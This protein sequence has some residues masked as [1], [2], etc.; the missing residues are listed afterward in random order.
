LIARCGSWVVESGELL[1]MLGLIV[2]RWERRVEVVDNSNRFNNLE[3][4][5]LWRDDVG[6]GDSGKMG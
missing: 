1:G 3:F 5:L 4:R 6:K 2:W